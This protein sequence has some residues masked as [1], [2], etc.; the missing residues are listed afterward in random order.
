MQFASHIERI[1]YLLLEDDTRYIEKVVAKINEAI[2]LLDQ[3]E[4]RAFRQW[5]YLNDRLPFDTAIIDSWFN[6]E[7]ADKGDR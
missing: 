3:H 2:P 6:D 7:F 4:R 5:L 1:F